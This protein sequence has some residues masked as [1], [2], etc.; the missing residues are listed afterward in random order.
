MRLPPS[1]WQ[2][3]WSVI[4]APGAVVQRPDQAQVTDFR[5][6]WWCAP[7]LD[8]ARAQRA[9]GLGRCLRGG[10]AFSRRHRHLT[11]AKPQVQRD[12][13][14]AQL[15]PASGTP[16][17][18]AR[19]EMDSVPMDIAPLNFDAAAR[20]DRP[21]NHM[22]ITDGRAMGKSTSDAAASRSNWSLAIALPP[23]SP[24]PVRRPS[25]GGSRLTSHGRCPAK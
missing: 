3:G 7:Q 1:T 19:A 2:C 11:T 9:A 22:W 14:D 20:L 6:L 15:R 5:C 17:L 13:A 21:D 25:T 23:D 4:R 12:E 18:V 8:E 16:A 24:S 10:E